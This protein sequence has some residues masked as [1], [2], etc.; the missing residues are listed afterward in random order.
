MQI[1]KMKRLTGAGWAAGAAS[2]FLEL[3]PEESALIELKLN[4][5]ARVRERRVKRHI[6]QAE[7]ARRLGSS[8][9]RIAKLEAGDPSVSLDLMVRALFA[10]GATRRELAKALAA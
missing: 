7:L 2:D 4:L 3:T 8:Q 9:S 5:S 1:A 6:S 10:T